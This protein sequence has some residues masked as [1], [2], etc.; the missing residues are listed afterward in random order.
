[1]ELHP[2]VNVVIQNISYISEPLS[3][4]LFLS[5]PVFSDLIRVRSTAGRIF[6]LKFL[7]R[8]IMIE[9]RLG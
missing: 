8:S 4:R 7:W 9:Q 3:T 6:F 2:S 1:V 5:V